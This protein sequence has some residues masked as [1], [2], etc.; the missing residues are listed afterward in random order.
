LH[1]LPAMVA[2]RITSVSLFLGLAACSVGEV[3]IG[4]VQPPADGP[5]ATPDARA[6]DGGV[7]PDAP[8]GGGDPAASYMT[9]VYPLVTNDTPNGPACNT[10]GCHVKGGLP[11]DFSSYTALA[12]RYR[13]KPG[14]MAKIVTKGKHMGPALTD[15][16][17]TKIIDWINGL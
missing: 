16:S 8:G 3:P 15:A 2:L 11:P 5:A 13:T 12:E 14:E 10:G 9:I 6:G 17:K 7:T 1:R 4:G